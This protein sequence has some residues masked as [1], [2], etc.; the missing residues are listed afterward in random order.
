MAKHKPLCDLISR[1]LT[2]TISGCIFVG[3]RMFESIVY[4][5]F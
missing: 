1:P 2:V 3:P 5:N 4:W